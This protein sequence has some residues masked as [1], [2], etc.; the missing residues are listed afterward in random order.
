MSETPYRS[1]QEYKFSGKRSDWKEWKAN[2]WTQAEDSGYTVVLTGEIICPSEL[3]YGAIKSPDY[4]D[5]FFMA[6]IFQLNQTAFSELIMSIDR[7]QPEGKA[8]L[9][10][11]RECTTNELPKVPR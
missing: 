5:G 1:L 7:H 8:L 2:W 6:E 10:L 11:R 9:A 3:A 4:G